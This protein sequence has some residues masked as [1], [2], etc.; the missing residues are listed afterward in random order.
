MGV[1]R[2][3]G[4]SIF[5]RIVPGASSGRSGALRATILELEVTKRDE[6]IEPLRRIHAHSP[7]PSAW[8][9]LGTIGYEIVR[10]FK[11]RRC[12]E[13]G[14]FGGFSTCA[15][16]LALRDLRLGGIIAAVDTWEG[17]ADTK[18]YGSEVY[19]AFLSARRE[20]GLE[21]VIQPMRMT[22]QEASRLIEP[23][24]DLL[25]IDALHRFRAVRRDFRLFRPLLAPNALVLFHD[26]NTVFR[27]MRL[28][29][30]LISARYPSC[31]IP[32]S[33]GLGIIRVG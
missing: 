26:V 8:A 30:R 6:R 7:A 28:F 15:M 10:H 27:G 24:I 23:G 33:Q 14:S 2:K 9:G 17:D 18:R 1:L 25:H 5:D 20:L 32:Y 3:L 16:G 4:G 19:E 11:P 12:V 21:Q 22:F 31:L 29:W 13:L